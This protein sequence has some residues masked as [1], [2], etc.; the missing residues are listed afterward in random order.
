MDTNVSVRNQD[1]G[2]EMEKIPNGRYTKKFREEAV[3]VVT[4]GGLSVLETS[5][6]LSLPKSTLEHWLRVS[7]A[8]SLGEIGKGQ[9][10]LT[11]I[12][13]ELAKVKR[14][15][16]LAKM[17]WGILKKRPRTLPMSRWKVRGDQGVA[18]GLLCFAAMPCAGGDEKRILCLGQAFAYH[19][20]AGG[21]E[22]GTG[23]TCCS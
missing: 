19:L 17:E 23:D 2:V 6:R 3:K 9:R 7:K 14:E 21:D 8:G 5:K 16:S 1:G 18:T 12:E 13:R 10:P 11:D 20:A 22:T 15:L 4:D